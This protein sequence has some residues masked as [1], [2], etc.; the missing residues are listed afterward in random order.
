MSPK[1]SDPNPPARSCSPSVRLA[2]TNKRRDRRFCFGSRKSVAIKGPDTCAAFI[3]AR[4]EVAYKA[5]ADEAGQTV[6]LDT[7]VGIKPRLTRASCRS[8]APV[9]RATR[10]YCATMITKSDPTV[11]P[12]L[13]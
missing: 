11:A 7:L 8:D 6:R 1:N 13:V 9:R 2:A 5:G 10:P 3:L 4:A 12:K